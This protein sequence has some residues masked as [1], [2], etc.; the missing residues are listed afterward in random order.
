[1]RRSDHLERLRTRV[2]ELETELD[3]LRSRFALMQQ[4]WTET[5]DRVTKAYKRVERANQ[6]QALRETP[7]APP[8][9]VAEPQDPFSRKL[10]QIRR[11]GGA[12]P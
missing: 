5:L 9:P 2:H 1:M 6:R 4:E 3:S 11:Q 7:V 10:A 8:E 12:L